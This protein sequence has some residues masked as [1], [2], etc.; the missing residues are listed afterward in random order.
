MIITFPG[1]VGNCA[2][3]PATFMVGG[4]V[5]ASNVTLSGSPATQNLVLSRSFTASVGGAWG[6][7]WTGTARTL[8]QLNALTG[9]S[10]IFGWNNSAQQF[11]F[12]FLGFPSNFQTLPGLQPGGYYFFQTSG[13]VTVPMD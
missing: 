11:N 8:A 5:A 12:W 7:L 6:Q 13:G 4:V 2:S 1:S 10:A 3:G 9:V